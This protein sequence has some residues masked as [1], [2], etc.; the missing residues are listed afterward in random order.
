MASGHVSG[1]AREVDAS[2][3]SRQ[4]VSTQYADRDFASIARAKRRTPG[5]LGVSMRLL[6]G[7]GVSTVEDWLEALSAD[8]DMVFRDTQGLVMK[9]GAQEDGWSPVSRFVETLSFQ[10]VETGEVY[11]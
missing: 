5:T 2:G 6:P 7:T 1:G 8:G 4:M 10:I 11:V 3:R 9:G